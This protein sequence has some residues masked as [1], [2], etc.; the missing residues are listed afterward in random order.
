M[1]EQVTYE[2][3]APTS[4]EGLAHADDGSAVLLMTD[5]K[6]R[7]IALSMPLDELQRAVSLIASKQADDSV[8]VP[9]RVVA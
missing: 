9:L 7:R 4:I 6:G 8:R 1:T 5:A 2:L 3:Y